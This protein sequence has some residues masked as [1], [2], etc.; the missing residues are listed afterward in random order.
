MGSDFTA[1]EQRLVKALAWLKANTASRGARVRTLLASLSTP[2]HRDDE[3]IAR[4]DL[5]APGSIGERIE[6]RL[7]RLAL[8]RTA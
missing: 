4:M 1:V 2:A 3:A 6:A 5:A 8:A 7:L